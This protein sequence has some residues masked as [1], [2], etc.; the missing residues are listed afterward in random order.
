MVLALLVS[1]LI[2]H[3]NRLKAV[4]QNLKH[5]LFQHKTLCIAT[6]L[7]ILAASISVMV[8]IHTRAALGEWKA[9]YIEPILL[10]LLLIIEF[11]HRTPQ[12]SQNRTE[13]I[14]Y[15]LLSPL[16]LLGLITTILALYQHATGW[17][18]PWDFWE[19]RNTY[20]VTGWYG[21]PNG[22]GIF[23]APLIPLAIYTAISMIKK[24]RT[25]TL[26]SKEFFLMSTSVIFLL[27]APFAILFAKST[28]AVIGVVAG[29]GTLLL[30]YKKTRVP[31]IVAGIM[32]GI[33]LFLLPNQNAIKQELLAQD[34]SGQIRVQMWGEAVQYLTEHPVTGAGLASYQTRIYPY[35]IDKWIEVF[36]HPHNIF[37]SMWMNLGV[38]GLFAF[39]WLLV[40]YIRV[41]L[42]ERKQPHA[43]TIIPFLLATMG[44]WL[45]TGLV[46]TPYSKNDWSIFFWLLIALLIIHT[47]PPKMVSAPQ[48]K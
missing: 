31:T 35:R 20:R 5:V 44:V 3:K 9:F 14:T 47:T 26:L 33:I 6:G 45:T 25:N 7:F 36:H 37:L 39:V 16:I 10:F 2:K 29:V 38:L 34:R 15:T 27:T 19:N 1:S 28:G 22:V 40:W 42:H 18:V 13:K 32:G 17:M 21:F 48:K 24:I 41:C 43:A 11:T 30:W 4:I 46:D 8:S 23:L 12:N